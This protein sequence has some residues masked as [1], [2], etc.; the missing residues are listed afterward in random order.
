MRGGLASIVAVVLA[1]GGCIDVAEHRDTDPTVPDA[2][3]DLAAQPITRRPGGTV[4][5][6]ASRGHAGFT[7]FT[8][9]WHHKEDGQVERLELRRDG[10]FDWTIDRSGTTCTIAGTVVLAS[11]AVAEVQQPALTWTMTTNTCNSS[12]QGKVASDVIITHSFEHLV[13][14]DAEFELEPVAYDREQ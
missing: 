12:Y 8:G 14:K 3:V 11:V 13:I 6:E 10:S 4:R 9:V 2:G 1:A 7:A 5:V